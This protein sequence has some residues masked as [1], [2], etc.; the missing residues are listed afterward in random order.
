M[1]GR[2]DKFG[3]GFDVVAKACGTRVLK[4]PV[5]APK[6]NAFCE[7]FIGSVRRELLDHVFIISEEQMGA[8]CAGHRLSQGRPRTGR[9][10]GPSRVRTCT[11][12]ALREAA[13]LAREHGYHSSCSPLSFWAQVTADLAE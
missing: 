12:S 6:A 3:D 2:D 7:R 13:R 8:A 4:T 5:R 9:S 11:A 1:R 10:S